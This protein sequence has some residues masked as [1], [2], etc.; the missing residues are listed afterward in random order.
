[1][2]GGLPMPQILF[3]F[4][5]N[6]SFE[7]CWPRCGRVNHGQSPGLGQWCPVRWHTL[8]TEGG[9][10]EGVRRTMENLQLNGISISRQCCEK[11][12]RWGMVRKPEI[13]CYSSNRATSKH[14][15]SLSFMDLHPS[16]FLS[17]YHFNPEYK[18]V[19]SNISPRK[20]DGAH[21][22]TA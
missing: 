5:R 4:A 8:Q 22:V 21:Y 6:F 17:V 10:S 12:L 1:M 2:K 20:G 13:S 11:G 14:F 15:L 3:T 19:V 7:I 9:S 18:S 16:I